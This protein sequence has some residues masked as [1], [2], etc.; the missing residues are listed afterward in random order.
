M[1]PR[2]YTQNRR[3]PRPPKRRETRDAEAQT[4]TLPRPTGP[5]EIGSTVV[6][7]DL[8]AALGVSTAAVISEL[9]RNGIFATINQSIDYDTAS[10]VAAEMG[11]ELVAKGAADMILTD[12]NFASIEAAV[13]EGRNVFDNLTKF[14]VWT[15]PTNA[16]EGLV[17]L[18]S[19][20]AGVALPALPVQMLWISAMI[21][22]SVSLNQA[23]LAPPA[24]EMPF[25]S[26]PG[27]SYFSKFTPR[28]FSSA[29]SRSRSSTC[30][31]A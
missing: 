12:D 26:I 9:I 19:I 31:N 15:L 7:Q 22:P 11:M 18:A 4:A 2:R 1:P 17:I 21:F 16:G 28:A 5:V 24:V 13:E 14:I 10:L 3:G 20:I 8:A 29:I 27:I 30:Q 25:S 6:V 23:A